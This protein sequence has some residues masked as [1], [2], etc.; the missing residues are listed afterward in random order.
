M[1]GA[2]QAGHGGG[3]VLTAIFCLA[4]MPMALSTCSRGEVAAE[5]VGGGEAPV[6]PPLPVGMGAP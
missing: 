6:A 2:W 1:D 5:A 4:M 3:V